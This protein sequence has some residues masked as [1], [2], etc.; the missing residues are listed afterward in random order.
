MLGALLA[1]PP[2]R[3]PPPGNA[4]TPWAPAAHPPGR[5]HDYRLKPQAIDDIKAETHVRYRPSSPLQKLG[6]KAPQMNHVA[7]TTCQALIPWGFGH[8]GQ[9]AS[10][11]PCCHFIKG[12]SRR[13]SCAQPFAFLLHRRSEARP[14]VQMPGKLHKRQKCALC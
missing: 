11:L 12:D 7:P 5:M 1:S 2:P 9:T 13:V 10:Y 8:M 3:P 4:A 6:R 14:I